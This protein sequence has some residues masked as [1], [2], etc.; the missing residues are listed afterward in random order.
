MSALAD[1]NIEELHSMKR[2]QLQTLCKKHG[3]KA[4]G[5]NEELIEQLVEAQN[6]V[7]DNNDTSMSKSDDDE[8]FHEAEEA[9]AQDKVFKVMPTVN[10]KPLEMEPP[11]NMELVKNKEFPSLAEKLTAEMEARAAAMSAEERKEVLDKYNATNEALLKT[12]NRAK[13]GKS[14]L[15]DKAH[16]KIFNNDDSIVNHWAANKVPGSTPQ[17]KRSNADTSSATTSKRPRLEPLFSSPSVTRSAVQSPAQRRKSTKTR[18]MTAKARRTA[19]ATAGTVNGAQ[20]VATS[21]RVKA[22][23]GDLTSTTLFAGSASAT[24][25]NIEDSAPIAEPEVEQRSEDLA[26]SGNLEPTSK[27]EPASGLSE[28]NETADQPADKDTQQDTPNDKVAEAVNNMATPQASEPEPTEQKEI[29]KESEAAEQKEAVEET[30]VAEQKETT[31]P[32]T[33]KAE[34]AQPSTVASGKSS[35][36]TKVNA[37]KADPAK[38]APSKISA[39]TAGKSALRP[40]TSTK[41]ALLSRPTLIPTSRKTPG[42]KAAGQPTGIPTKGIQ[43]A[44]KLSVNSNSAGSAAKPSAAKPMHKPADYSNVQSKLKSYINAKPAVAS[45]PKSS[46]MPK[47]GGKSKPQPTKQPTVSAMPKPAAN[48]TVDGG[49]VPGYM[50]STKAA[51]MRSQGQ[52][53]PIINKSKAT[54]PNPASSAKPRFNPYG[55]PARPAPAKPSA[56]K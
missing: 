49:S 27:E 39:P 22:A 41:P 51:E 4:N 28:P 30:K 14:V 13:Q 9:P 47:A 5:K 36:T 44:K 7:A 18:A 35:E 43:P 6:T 40:P 25:T 42:S 45:K 37:Q 23:G 50:R 48:N 20:T 17:N 1:I 2:K 46:D 19:A 32:A 11:E 24:S 16:E 3:I 52:Q 34:P 21:T 15:F 55:R 38:P 12:P 10:S 8:E 31:K 26:E 29:A 54:G 56:A 33:D 53:P